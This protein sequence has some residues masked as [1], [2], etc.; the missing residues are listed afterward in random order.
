MDEPSVA[1]NDLEAWIEK[2]YACKPLTEHEV[3]LLCEKAR[4]IFSE[5]SNVQPVRAPV[6]VCG[7]I[8]GQLH[9]SISLY[10]LFNQPFWKAN[11][12]NTFHFRFDRAVQDR[13]R[14]S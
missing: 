9:G 1:F 5:E 7:D 10:T 13:W 6:T 12:Y 14:L 11:I 4:E 2:L 3:K 8:H